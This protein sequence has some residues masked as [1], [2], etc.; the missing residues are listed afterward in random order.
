MAMFSATAAPGESTGVEALKHGGDEALVVV[1]GRF[2]IEV[3]GKKDYLE[4][5]DSV[6]IRRGQRHRLTNVGKDTGQ[7]IFVLSPPAY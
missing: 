1:S 4:P 5:G 3:E 7:A 2:E 6:F